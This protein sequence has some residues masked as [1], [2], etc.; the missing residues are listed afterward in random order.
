MSASVARS[1][2]QG[3]EALVIRNGRVT[4]VIIP[5][6][7]GRVWELTDE[8]RQRQW[9][10]HRPGFPLDNPPPEPRYDDVW[11]GGWEELFPNDAPGDFEGKNLPDHG[12]WWSLP[13]EVDE[14]RAGGE[15]VVRLSTNTR[16][17][18]AACTKEFRLGAE[19][20]TMTVSYRIENAAPEPFHFLFKQHLPVAIT[21]DCRLLLPDGTVTAV[22]PTFGTL[23]PGPGPYACPAPVVTQNGKKDLGDIPPPDGLS[24]EFVYVANLSRGWCGVADKTNRAELRL[25]WDRARL[26][27]LW[28]FL[29][30]GGWRDCYTAVLE[31]CTNMPKDLG[32]AT[33]AGQSALLRAGE[34]FETTVAVTLA[35]VS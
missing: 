35:S 23:L 1:V 31:P 21:P 29:S 18:P 30:Y 13:W 27:F 7:G 2:V 34:V 12:E 10:W 11:T 14:V 5:S 16:N 9:I 24:R 33:R 8:R 28:L 6:L 26:P 3:F 17:R 25:S 20:N 15:A 22:D 19:S 4:A 32:E